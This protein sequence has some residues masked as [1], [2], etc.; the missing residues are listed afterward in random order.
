[1]Q[2]GNFLYMYGLSYLKQHIF[3]ISGL[4]KDVRAGK[5]DDTNSQGEAQENPYHDLEE[6]TRNSSPPLTTNSN[7]GKL[8]G[9]VFSFVCNIFLAIKLQQNY[10]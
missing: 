2:L 1:M 3:T 8:Y 6:N 7:F 5:D 10:M 4:D 9:N